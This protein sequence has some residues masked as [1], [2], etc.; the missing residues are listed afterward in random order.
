MP[1]PVFIPNLGPASQG[2][3][4]S[5]GDESRRG[6]LVA[7]ECRAGDASAPD[8][9]RLITRVYQVDAQ[10]RPV[11]D[12]AKQRVTI[13]ENIEE[14]P[15]QE[16]LYDHAQQQMVAAATRFETAGIAIVLSAPLIAPP[17]PALSIMPAPGEPIPESDATPTAAPAAA[18]APGAQ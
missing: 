5:D 12:A 10:G 14:F 9:A 13:A 3:Q 16:S 18:V 11:L 17:A 15:K 7:V 8:L 2:F 1:R 4:L 6:S